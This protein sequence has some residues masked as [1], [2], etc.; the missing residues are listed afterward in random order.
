MN[1][2]DVRRFAFEGIDLGRVRS[3]L[4]LGC[5]FGFML[6]TVASQ[7]D[8]DARWVGVDA[9]E[10]NRAPFLTRLGA[11]GRGGEFIGMRIDEHLPWPDASFDLVVCSYSLYFFPGAI[12]DIARVLAPDGVLVALTHHAQSL[13]SLLSACGIAPDAAPLT[14]LLASFSAENGGGMLARHFAQV[15]KREY[16]NALRFRRADLDDLLLY[17][18]FK[19]PLLIPDADSVQDLPADIRRA[20]EEFLIRHGE[21]VLE[22]DDACFHARMPR[23]AQ[24]PEGGG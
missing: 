18:R 17:A 15:S 11:S 21:V 24:A 16:P 13:R 7:L 3:I 12:P 6:E 2:A 5:G 9:C 19:L 22:K 20:I 4:D 8:E 1:P 14:R 10:P 23:P